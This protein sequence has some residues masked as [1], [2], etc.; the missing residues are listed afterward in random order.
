MFMVWYMSYKMVSAADIVRYTVV[1]HIQ[2]RL[3]TDDAN[4]R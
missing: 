1:I 2:G 3:P 4:A